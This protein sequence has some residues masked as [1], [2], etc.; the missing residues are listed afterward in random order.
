[1]SNS[2]LRDFARRKSVAQAEIQRQILLA[3]VHDLSSS[4][5][6]RFQAHL[7]LSSFC[8][9]SSRSRVRA[10]CQITGRSRGVLSQWKLSRILFRKLAQ[11]GL[12]A[13]VRKSSW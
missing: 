10:R 12:L 8:R 4:P 2:I 5:S 1:M 11:Q 6:Q 7:L 3:Q 13:G 9:D